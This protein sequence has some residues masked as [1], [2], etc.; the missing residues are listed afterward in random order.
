MEALFSK[1]KA[2]REAKHLTLSDISEATLIEEKFL[3][4]IEEGNMSLLPQ[5]YVRAFIRAYAK[6]VGLDPVEMMQLY[7][8]ASPAETIAPPVDQPKPPAPHRDDASRLKTQM[9]NG[10]FA[11]LILV[12]IGIGVWNL[13]QRQSA[14]PVAETPFQSV[15]KE[16]ERRITPD[17]VSSQDSTVRQSIPETGDSLTLG[18]V[19]SD[20]VWVHLT[21]DGK[22]EREYLF[23]PNTAATWKAKDKFEVSLGN[24]G[25]IEFTLQGH[26]LGALGKRG[27][28]LRGT[29][30]NRETIA[31]K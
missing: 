19:V 15:V 7:D 14:P 2:A 3:R 23:K 5:T 8:G 18:A 10:V 12:L 24:A 28:V 26:K 20:S 30:L 11:F 6:V 29:V 17:S 1:L 9:R 13:T 27:A 22:V 4:A 25:A 21:I 16:K 31:K